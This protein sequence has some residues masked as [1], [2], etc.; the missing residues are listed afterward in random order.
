MSLGHGSTPWLELGPRRCSRADGSACFRGFW[1]LFTHENASLD[2]R[3]PLVYERLHKATSYPLQCQGGAFTCG[4]CPGAR[5][6]NPSRSGWSRMLRQLFKSLPQLTTARFQPSSTGSCGST[7]NPCAARSTQKPRAE[8]P[9]EQALCTSCDKWL[10]D[11]KPAG[12]AAQAP[13]KSRTRAQLPPQSSVLAR[14][15]EETE[16]RT[17]VSSRSERTILLCEPS[18][19]SACVHGV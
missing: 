7:W 14:Y 6:W 8:A 17:H 4:A 9:H 10:R 15:L 13:R 5:N 19:S 3:R 11:L 12:R 16:V 2:N 1:E 18:P